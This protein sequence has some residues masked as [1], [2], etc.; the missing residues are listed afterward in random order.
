MAQTPKK[1][2]AKKADATPKTPT[3]KEE[4]HKLLDKHAR[5]GAL[6][7]VWTEAW[8]EYSKL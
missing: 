8:T 6:N 4:L 1:A 7:S 2:A 3:R 5:T